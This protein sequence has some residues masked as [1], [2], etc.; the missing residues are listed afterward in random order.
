MLH[1]LAEAMRRSFLLRFA[2]SGDTDKPAQRLD[3][4]YPRAIRKRLA[5]NFSA[6][7]ASKTEPM[8]LRGST[9]KQRGGSHT[10]H[11]SIVDRQGMAVS[12]THTINLLFGA[13]IVTPKSGVWLNNELDDFAYTLSDSN[14]FGL[15][16][17]R[18][19]LFRPGARPT[20]SMTPTIVVHK[21]QPRLLLGA[22][23]GTRIPTSVFLTAFWHLVGGLDLQAASDHFRIHHQALA[24]ELWL[25]EGDDGDAALDAIKARGHEVV[26][27]VPWC[28]VQAIAIHASGGEKARYE[29]V[30][31]KRGGGG[32]MCL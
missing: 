20:S 30:C 27:R 24:D 28:N 2:Y 26:R 4:V 8:I 13:A 31:D 1:A 12:S 29:A 14:A 23:G 32:A 5:R 6:K 21:G 18:A 10:S 9:T 16:G 25:E 15:A 7:K 22:P 11:V 19:G 3:D 17:N